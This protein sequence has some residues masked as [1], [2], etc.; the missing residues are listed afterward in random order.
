MTIAEFI[1]RI[2]AYYGEYPRPAIKA[3]VAAFL[4]SRGYSDEMLDE[5]YRLVIMSISTRYRT[6]PDVADIEEITREAMM[7]AS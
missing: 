6:V 1:K 3:H 7:S 5:L 4:K 2:E